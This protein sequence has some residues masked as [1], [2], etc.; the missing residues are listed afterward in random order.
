M[1]EIFQW[2]MLLLGMINNILKIQD[3]IT[4]GKAPFSRWRPQW[5]PGAENAYKL[6]F[7]V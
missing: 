4:T 2:I 3:K 6:G 1:K 7:N 5:L